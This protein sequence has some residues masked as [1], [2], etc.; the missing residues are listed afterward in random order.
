MLEPRS[1]GS[2][3]REPAL[4]QSVPTPSH[5]HL[6]RSL[7]PVPSSS[8]ALVGIPSARYLLARTTPAR[9]PVLPLH[10]LI[11]RDPNHQQHTLSLVGFSDTTKNFFRPVSSVPSQ[12]PPP[13][14]GDKSR[15]SSARPSCRRLIPPQ[16][17]TDRPSRHCRRLLPPC[18]LASPCA[19]CD[20]SRS[21]A[22]ASD[23][24]PPVCS[25]WPKRRAG[26]ANGP[27]SWPSRPSLA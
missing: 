13:F 14:A 23:P 20:P 16:T 12:P 19:F 27:K 11:H 17:P 7:D 22:R 24:P 1:V 21:T 5:H 2:I 9:P 18:L 3:R 8:L 4:R 26:S 15:V 10:L 25:P 6:H